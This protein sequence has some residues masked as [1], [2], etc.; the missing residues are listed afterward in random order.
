[1]I[2]RLGVKDTDGAVHELNDEVGL[3][4][5]SGFGRGFKQVCV[6]VWQRRILH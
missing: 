6:P 1:M 3:K 5:V 2:D 4:G